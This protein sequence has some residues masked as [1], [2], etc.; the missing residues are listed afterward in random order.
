M[1]IAFAITRIRTIA[2]GYIMYI[3][4]PDDYRLLIDY[5]CIS[6]KGIYAFRNVWFSV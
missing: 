3:T 4:I 2:K 1:V 6:F 5:K